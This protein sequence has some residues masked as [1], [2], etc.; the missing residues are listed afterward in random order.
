MHMTDEH[1]AQRLQF[2]MFLAHSKLSALSAIDQEDPIR[3]I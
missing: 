3:G 2:E 1:M